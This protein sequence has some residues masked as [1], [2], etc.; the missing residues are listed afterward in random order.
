MMK[1]KYFECYQESYSLKFSPE[2]TYSL[3]QNS[4]CSLT[5]PK[6]NLKTVMSFGGLM[7]PSLH[8]CRDVRK[9]DFKMSHEKR[10]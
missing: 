9:L 8:P 5:F 6:V 2:T 3:T 1:K 7:V 10:C 4:S